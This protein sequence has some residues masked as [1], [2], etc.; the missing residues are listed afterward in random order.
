MACG[1]FS[2]FPIDF[3]LLADGFTR[4]ITEIISKAVPS[5]MRKTIVFCG[6]PVSVGAKHLAIAP[7]ARHEDVL[8]T[9][10]AIAVSFARR[11]RSPYIVFKEFPAS[12]CP[13]MDFLQQL[14]YRRFS[15]PAMNTFGRQ[16]PDMDSY[17]A[18][19]RSRYRQ[20]VRKIAGESSCRRPATTN[21]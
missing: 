19:L 9:M 17:T 13:T 21:A 12:D 3:N 6:L 2:A 14:G 18:A 16:F 8:R 4:R 7:W 5:L 15:S 10:H 20:C 11:E 1:S